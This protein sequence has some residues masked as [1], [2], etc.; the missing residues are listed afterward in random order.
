VLVD[1]VCILNADR[2]HYL[3]FDGCLR[4][5]TKVIGGLVDQQRELVVV[6]VGQNGLLLPLPL[7]RSR[8]GGSGR[9]CRFPAPPNP[10][11]VRIR[12]GFAD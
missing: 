11:A 9:D 3:N 2:V 4:E 12:V 1:R 8:E 10:S 6:V 7:L 5:L